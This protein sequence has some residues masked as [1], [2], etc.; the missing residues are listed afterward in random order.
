MLCSKEKAL[1]SSKNIEMLESPFYLLG[2]RRLHEGK[3]E[4]TGHVL[5]NHGK[6]GSFLLA[7]VLYTF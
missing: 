5:Y 3:K 4:L 6:C 1:V 7:A 2:L